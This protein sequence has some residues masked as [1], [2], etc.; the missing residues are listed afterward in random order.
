MTDNMRAS[1]GPAL[2][3]TGFKTASRLLMKVW[4]SRRKLPNILRANWPDFDALHTH[5]WKL[6]CVY[7]DCPSTAPDNSDISANANLG[8]QYWI[9][10]ESL[11]SDDFVRLLVYSTW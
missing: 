9:V 10:K 7:R 3:E 1:M 6:A 4:P 5:V 2:F 8:V 11:V